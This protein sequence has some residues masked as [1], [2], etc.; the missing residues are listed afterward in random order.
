MATHPTKPRHPSAHHLDA[1]ARDELSTSEFAFPKQR[2]E[3]L[4]DAAH[5]RNAIA[6]FDQV[7]DASDDD[8]AAAF[9]RIK[10]A[11]GRFGIE[12]E[13]ESWRDLGKPGSASKGSHRKPTHR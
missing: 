7:E 4:V 11:A 1:E 5:V 12:M 3:P 10:R 8:R 2:K 13:A 9:A 6:R